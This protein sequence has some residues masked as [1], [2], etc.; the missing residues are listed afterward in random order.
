MDQDLRPGEAER[1]GLAE[2][3]QNALLLGANWNGTADLLSKS[4]DCVIGRDKKGAIVFWNPAAEQLYGWKM[5]EAR[6]QIA[7]TLLQT[8]F[9]KPF[10]EI[11]AELSVRG[12]WEGQLEHRTRDGR[13]VVVLSRW[14][15]QTDADGN[16]AGLVQQE[17]ELTQQRELHEA[18]RQARE[19]LEQSA[20]QRLREL[21]TANEALVE[22][23]ARVRQI[24]E[25]IHDIV[26]LTNPWRTS[27]LYVNPAYEQIWGR[28]C[29]SLYADPQSW[30]E[31]VH[32]EDRPRLRRFFAKF[33]SPQ[34][35]EQSYRIVRPDCSARW[36]LDRGFAVRDNAGTFYRVVGIIR[37]VTE[38]KELEKEILAISEREQR[39]I[40]QD[41]HDDLCQ[42]LAGIEFLSRALQEHL[43]DQSQAAKA[44]EIAKLIRQSIE[45]T[46]QLA[47][48]LAPVELEAD[49]LMRG[50]QRLAKSTSHLFNVRCLMQCQAGFSVQDPTVSTH[51]YRIAQEAV[52]NSIKHGQA[53]QIKIMVKAKPQGG[54][55]TIQDN[56]KGL[57][58]EA[59]VSPGMGLRIMR[60]RADM[61]GATLV[62][63]TGATGGT[64]IVCAFPLTAW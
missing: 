41:L 49:G 13:K 3:Q 63:E 29:Q 24:G 43:D 6:G 37:D 30:L 55:L 32:P 27:T 14:S 31:G 53:T 2:E 34:C 60:Y 58:S 54:E 11:E 26:W 45:Y 47:R 46:R 61:I 28:S 35:H 1:G 18:L 22:S 52:A 64:T 50:L 57:P 19:A 17:H 40:G 62:T 39:R 42:Q 4:H 15:L 9:P 8:N 23:Q 25:A 5:S 56:G 48:G 38:R 33:T 44:E 12:Q 16:R 21:D 10:S 51:L 36:V 7:E 59:R 20:E